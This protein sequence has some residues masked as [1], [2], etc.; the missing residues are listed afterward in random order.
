MFKNKDK[1]QVGNLVKSIDKIFFDVY[2][3]KEQK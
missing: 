2:N 3:G 1:V